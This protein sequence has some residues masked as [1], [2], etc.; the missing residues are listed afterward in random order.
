MLSAENQAVYDALFEL[1]GDGEGYKIVDADEVVEKL[2]AGMSFTKVQLSQI[3]RDL[4]DRECVDIKYFTPDQ[5]C[6]R[7]IKI[8]HEEPQQVVTVPQSD[9]MAEQASS[10]TQLTPTAKKERRLYGEKKSREV[11]GI[12]RGTLFF[13]SFLGSLFGGGIVAAITAVLLKFAI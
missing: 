3:I 6:L 1:A 10:E 7:V 8:I 5:Y 12:R 9:D 2:P 4:K 11:S 13:M